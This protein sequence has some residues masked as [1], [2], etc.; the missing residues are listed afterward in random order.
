MHQYLPHKVT[1]VGYARS[2]YTPEEFRAY[3]RPFLASGGKVAP[4]IIER[5]LSACEYFYGPYDSTASFAAMDR[6]LTALGA[7]SDVSNR[8][9]YFALPPNV[10]IQ[11]ATAI[12]AAALTKTGWYRTRHIL[13]LLLHYTYKSQC[14]SL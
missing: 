12:H 7:D 10:F 2:A 4:E 14:M 11:T 9:F 5:F 8:L 3:I 1:I 6:Q 13:K